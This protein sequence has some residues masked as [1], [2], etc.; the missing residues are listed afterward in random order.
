[1]DYEEGLLVVCSILDLCFFFSRT[2][3]GHH[4]YYF[5]L[6][7]QRVVEAEKNQHSLRGQLSSAKI[8]TTQQLVCV[9]LPYILINNDLYTRICPATIRSCCFTGW[10]TPKKCQ[11]LPSNAHGA[12]NS[13][14][15]IL[16]AAL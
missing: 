9:Q 16:S 4:F 2:L 1:M 11:R 15:R 14:L 10:K 5:S 13:T 3:T 12:G 8:S 6:F 7:Y